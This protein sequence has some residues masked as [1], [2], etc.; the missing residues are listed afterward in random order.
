LTVDFIDL[1][2]SADADIKTAKDLWE[3]VLGKAEG[4]TCDIEDDD[5]FGSVEDA[6]AAATAVTD[7]DVERAGQVAFRAGL[8]SPGPPMGGC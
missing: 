3:Y 4:E 6:K 8:A 2:A 1:L 5:P 7:A